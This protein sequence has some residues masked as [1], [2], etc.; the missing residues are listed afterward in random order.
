MKSSY[1]RYQVVVSLYAPVWVLNELRKHAEEEKLSVSTLV[2]NL[3]VCALEFG[4]GMRAV[5]GERSM[6]G[7][8]VRRDGLSIGVPWKLKGEVQK[9]ANDRK[10]QFK[11]AIVRLIKLGL[12]ILYDVKEGG[13]GV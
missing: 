8:K 2:S 3:F 9:Y 7:E 12:M 11:D 13:S 6:D 4:K 1:G 10:M 5:D